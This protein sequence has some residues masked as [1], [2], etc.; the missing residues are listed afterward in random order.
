MDRN[1]IYAEGSGGAEDAEDGGLS[2]PV[3][4][5]R[6][7]AVLRVL[8]ASAALCVN[9]FCFP[10]RAIQFGTLVLAILGAVSEAVAQPISCPG[11]DD[12]PPF[13]DASVNQAFRNWLTKSSNLPPVCLVK[14]LAKSPWVHSDSAIEQSIIL[15]REM[16]RAN[17]N[18]PDIWAARAILLYRGQHYAEVEP[19]VNELFGT[20]SRRIDLAIEKAVV[21]S[22]FRL[23]DT[24]A[25][26][27]HLSIGAGR[28]PQYRHF[29]AELRIFEQL[30]RLHALVDTVHRKMARDRTLIAGYAS[31]ASI[32]GNLDM[33]DSALSYTRKAIEHGVKPDVIGPAHETIVGVTMRH[34][35]ILDAPDSWIA[36]LP[37]ARAIDS[38]Y[39]TPASKYLLALSLSEV[40]ADRTRVAKEVM[41]GGEA[42]AITGL[43]H[44][45]LAPGMESY[46]RVMSCPRLDESLAQIAESTSILD[47]GGAQFDSAGTA[48]IRKALATMQSILLM[49]KPA[50]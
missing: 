11:N 25:I 24:V 40:V 15:T 28:F 14:W 48:S 50:C 20:D 8:R 16:G 30:P 42:D 49:L 39:S 23:H 3:Y 12:P 45:H 17:P 46:L 31:L 7:A 22:A 2:G 44:V 38:T 37:R 47:A 36:T 21:A 13:V 26:K 43:T 5:E 27:R 9:G 18:D 10:R 41:S 4:R 33:L 29:G 6:A 19:A 35:Q 34:A 32:Y 1:D